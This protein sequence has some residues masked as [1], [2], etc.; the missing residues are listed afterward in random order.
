MFPMPFWEPIVVV[1]AE[2]LHVLMVKEV[3]KK[4][5]CNQEVLAVVRLTGHLDHGVV[6]SVFNTL[7]HSLIQWISSVDAVSL[8]PTQ[9][10]THLVDLIH[11][12][13]R[14]SCFFCQIHQ[15]KDGRQGTLLKKRHRQ[16][17]QIGTELNLPLQ[18]ASARQKLQL[19]LVAELYENVN[20]PFVVIISGL[21]LI[22]PGCPIPVRLVRRETITRTTR[23][24]IEGSRKFTSN[25]FHEPFKGGLPIILFSQSRL[26]LGNDIIFYVLRQI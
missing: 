9:E 25:T 6:H 24:R 3:R 14:R 23:L 11:E 19:L 4:F 2:N 10:Q 12:R 26:P 15:V 16:T 8:F 1:K 5:R 17:G 7:V 22:S 20:R 18:T 21:I 13:E